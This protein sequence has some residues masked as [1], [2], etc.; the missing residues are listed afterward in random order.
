MDQIINKVLEMGAYDAKIINTSDLRFDSIF[1]KYCA[2]NKCGFYGNNHMCPPDVGTVEE[3]KSKVLQ[4]DKGIYFQT[5]SPI[6]GFSDNE[7]LEK[8]AFKHNNLANNIKKYILASG[9]EKVLPMGTKCRYCPE[10]SKI[11]GE[12]CIHPD[13]AISCLSAYCIDV[14]DMAKKLNME[15]LLGDKK[16]AY[17]GLVLFK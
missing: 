14:L 6:N 4:Y 5:I 12:P 2:D 8:A 17:F 3:V 10:C 9:Y 11:K 1:R 7:N 16:I 13:M 15:Y